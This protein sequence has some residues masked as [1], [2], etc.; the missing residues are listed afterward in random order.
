MAPTFFLAVTPPPDF[1][2][3]VVEFQARLG[4]VMTPPHIT[5]LAPNIRPE[6]D[7]A[8]L[9]RAVAARHRPVQIKLG[10]VGSFGSR[11]IFLTPTAP[12]LRPIHDD[13]VRTQGG[14]PGQFDL[15]N[16]HPHLSITLSWRPLAVSWTEALTQA[17]QTFSELD[18][19]P[20]RFTA[21]EL[22]LFKK[23]VPGGIYTEHARFALRHD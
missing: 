6:A 20:L 10:G 1:A 18:A 11:V 14:A 23:V 5:L 12:G 15:A 19:A 22:V 17:R 16:Y 9:A 13:L 2:A 7:W 8:T 3:R 21:A 4:H